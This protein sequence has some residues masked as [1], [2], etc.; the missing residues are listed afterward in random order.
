MKD[1]AAAAGVVRPT[2]CHYFK[3]KHDILYAIHDEFIDLLVSKHTARATAQPGITVEESL[4]SIMQDSLRLICTHR[5]H[6]RVFFECRRSSWDD[7]QL[8][9]R[10]KHDANSRTVIGLLQQGRAE[11]KF[12]HDPAVAAL[13]LSG[14]CNW[15]CQ[16]HHPGGALSTADLADEFWQILLSGIARTPEKPRRSPQRRSVAR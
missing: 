8:A 13:A 16:C 4:R 7:Q 9:I 1:S 12:S 6:V 5:G 2:S 10:A 3:S 14:I 11:G 15:A